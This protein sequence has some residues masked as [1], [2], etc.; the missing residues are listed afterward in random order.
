MR[1]YSRSLICALLGA[2]LLIGCTPTEAS[3]EI[4]IAPQ[5][6]STSTSLAPTKTTPEV[7]TV[8]PGASL[9]FSHEFQSSPQLDQS[10][11]VILSV[12]HDYSNAIME[13]SAY[14]DELLEVS[15]ATSSR[16]VQLLGPGTDTWS[17]RFTPKADGRKYINVQASIILD[18]GR[19]QSRSYAIRVDTGANTTGNPKSN[20]VTEVIMQAE[21]TISD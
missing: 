17:I 10:G 6:D 20:S 4:A 12:G 15:S 3:N 18:S 11:T 2:G 1:N 16:T 19:T 7:R 5:A 14:G 13:L 9:N 21:E 8:K